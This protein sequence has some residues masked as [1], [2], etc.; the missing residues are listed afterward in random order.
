MY[1][2]PDK[3]FWRLNIE[4]WSELLV[5][6]TWIIISYLFYSLLKP[7]CYKVST[8]LFLNIYITCQITF[9]SQSFSR[10]SL[11]GTFHFGYW[12]WYFSWEERLTRHSVSQ[13][14]AFPFTHCSLNTHMLQNILHIMRIHTCHL[15][16]HKPQIHSFKVLIA[17]Y[18]I[19]KSPRAIH[20]P[21]NRTH[22]MY[23]T[24]HVCV[25]ALK[26]HHMHLGR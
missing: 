24:S 12:T 8:L 25:I 11:S 26:L 19:F 20:S 22:I 17:Q 16:S 23:S 6:H 1:H 5:L 21:E 7:Y 3:R 4:L 10:T 13:I 9:F 15:L 2:S 18:R 14:L